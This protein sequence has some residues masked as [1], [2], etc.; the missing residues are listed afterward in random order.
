MEAINLFVKGNSVLN[1]AIEH[2]ISDNLV[3]H[4]TLELNANNYLFREGDDIR[5]TFYVQK[6]L[7]KLSS[8][9]V[10]GYSKTVFLHKAGTLLGFQGLQDL[11]NWK[12]SILNAKASMRST[13]IALNATDFEKYLRNNGDVCYEMTRYLFSMLALQTREAV[14]SSVYA[15]L[16]RFAAMLLKLAQELGATNEQALIPFINAELGE[17]LV[18][19]VNSINNAISSLRKTGCIDKQ[20]N[21]LAIIDFKKLTE[22]ADSLVGGEI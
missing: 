1:D 7:I 21:Y 5:Q 9:N 8:D 11:E 4:E 12:P 6:G 14:N 2:M 18:V 17:M 10:D 19:H 20:R 13:V 22:V 16:Q 15:V 3:R